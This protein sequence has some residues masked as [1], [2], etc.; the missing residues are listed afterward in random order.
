[1]KNLL[2]WVALFA[3]PMLALLLVGSASAHAMPAPHDLRLEH[4]LPL[5]IAFMGTQ[6][7]Q[8][9]TTAATTLNKAY[10]KMQGG[11]LKGY[12]SMSE[13]WDLYDDIPD[14]DITLSAREMTA[15]IDL[16][17]QGRSA[18]IPEGGLEDNPSTPNLEEVT[19]TWTNI[20]ERWM[21]T[22]TAKYLDSKA[23][24]GM[25]IRQFRYQAL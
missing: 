1:M 3:L 10:R 24:A 5:G 7:V 21:T 11:L 18:K 22:L 2:R 8:S 4:V 16:N 19:L 6:L 12:Q 13:E 9:I 15:P 20:N 17:P 14:Y 23:Q 25:I